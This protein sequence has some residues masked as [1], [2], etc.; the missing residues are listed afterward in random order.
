MD[1]PIYARNAV[2]KI[3]AYE[4]NNIFPGEKLILTFETESTILNTKTIE[5]LVNKYLV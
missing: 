3:E 2:K 1:D 5:K 4:N